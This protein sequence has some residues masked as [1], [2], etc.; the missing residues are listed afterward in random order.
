MVTRYLMQCTKKKV[1]SPTIGKATASRSDML[2]QIRYWKFKY[3][4]IAISEVKTDMNTR[5]CMYVPVLYFIQQI[6][7]LKVNS[8]LLLRENSIKH[9]E[10]DDIE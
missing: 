5:I 8:L 10:M 6:K 1:D 9:F 3:D 7:F 2:R 4:A